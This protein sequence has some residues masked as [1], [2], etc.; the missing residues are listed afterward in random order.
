MSAIAFLAAALMTAA[1]TLA[2]AQPSIV[3]APV[4]MALGA[5]A[6]PLPQGTMLV[7][8]T[9]V[10]RAVAANFAALARRSYGL[11]FAV[12]PS[13]ARG[14]PAIEWR[15]EEGD[16]RSEAY[17]LE[18]RRDRIV[19]ASPSREGLMH[20]AAS[21]WQLIARRHGGFEVPSV[22]IED[23]PRFAWRGVMLDSARHYQS[24]AFIRDYLDWMSVHKLNVLHWHLTD[25]Q[26]WRLE[27][28]KYPKLT[29][30]GAWRVPAGPLAARDID[31]ATG[32]PRLHGGFYSQETVRGLVAYAAER[33]IT[34]VPEIEMPGHASAAIAAYPMLAS[35]AD[36]PATVSPDW[37]VFPHAYNLD[38]ATF[39]FLEDVLREVMELFPG[40]YV[41]VGGDEVE[42]TEWKRSPAV[43][44]RM[45]ALGIGEATGVQ[46]YFTQRIGRFLA[47]NGRRLVGWDE[48]LEPGLPQESVVMSWRGIDGALAAAAKG[49]DT[50]LAAHPT[51]Y[52]DNRQGGAPDEPPGRGRVVSLEDVYAFEPMPPGIAEDARAHV[53]GLQANVWTEHIRTEDRAASMSFPRAAAVAE[54]GW[55]AAGKRNWPDF[56]RR[57]GAL[58]PRYRALGL[59][60]SDSAFAVIAAPR[61]EGG[62]AQVEL[63]N[64][65]RTGDIRYT[66]DGSE[67]SLASK[68]YSTPVS[69]RLPA[70]LRTAS[71]L[72][73]ERIAAPR[74]YRLSHEGEQARTSRDLALCSRGIDLALEDDA[75]LRGPR[76]VFLMDIQNP[77]WI[78]KD[79]KL[80]RVTGIEASVG[81]VPFNF[82]I[83]DEAAK[84]RFAAPATRDGELE[85][86]LDTCE[87]ELLAR[88][89][90]AP[91]AG[92]QG[93]TA[94]PRVAVEPRAGQ[95]DL[96]IRFAQAGHDPLW[97]LDAIRLTG[98]GS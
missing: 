49:Y 36:P 70:T 79:A 86:R 74:V 31:P 16:A 22:S 96:C 53:L 6:F 28:R 63:S 26:G 61:Y 54:L 19:V 94:L 40:R 9:P 17:R 60:A 83:G 92:S 59:P 56:A 75:P 51:L 78:Y 37:G 82:R 62:R 13:A 67:P 43:Q 44:E 93:V 91:A 48:I 76:A 58:M 98:A 2:V 87:G 15:L 18:V 33:G 90:L 20:G 57:V 77:C 73:G 12:A 80:D 38:E 81:Q 72:A 66:L 35:I 30:V 47:A 7:A 89:P 4:S 85:V 39:G 11:R 3:P 46:A 84:I 50:V 10:T 65:A 27:I 41:H 64:Q 68:L 69:I 32:R 25:D 42:T 29:S 88:L 24:P 55:S 14:R 71:F 52:L 21:L 97:A 45:K 1:A 95:H 23:A 34:I 5:G 8:A